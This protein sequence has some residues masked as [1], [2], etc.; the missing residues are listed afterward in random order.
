VGGRRRI[1]IAI[2]DIAALGVSVQTWVAISV[3][4]RACRGA[5]RG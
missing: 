1:A 5:P 4:A 2:F 3:P